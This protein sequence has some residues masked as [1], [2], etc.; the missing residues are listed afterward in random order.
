MSDLTETHE[1]LTFQVVVDAGDPHLLARFWAAALRYE[2]ED[3]DA[4]VRGLLDQGLVGDADVVEV[5][6]VLHFAAAVGIR[7]PGADQAEAARNQRLLFVAVPEAK[8]VKNRVHLD[9]HVAGP[10]RTADAEARLESEVARVEALGAT[11]LYRHDEA[12]G[13]W[14]T[15]A[16]PEGNE[17][18]LH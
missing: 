14:V 12:D 13:R 3:H 10:E 7:P 5:D 15:L 11:V 16:D 9:L 4:M 18:C 2:V 8:T 6:G 17:L 1:P